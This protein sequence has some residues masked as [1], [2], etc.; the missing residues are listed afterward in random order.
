VNPRAQPLVIGVAECVD[1]PAWKIR[2]LP[3][4]VDTGARSCALHV[5][6][7]REL[8]GGHVRFD[9]P[10]SPG[11][12][13][14]CMTIDA[15]VIRRGRV[16]STSGEAKP[17]LF[18][19]ARIR[20]GPLERQVELGLVDRRQMQFPMLIGRSAIARACLVD[21][22]RTYLITG[23]PKSKKQREL[24][25][26]IAAREKRV[27]RRK[28]DASRVLASHTRDGGRKRSQ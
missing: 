3:A 10:L 16:R 23:R 26:S 2:G 6:N 19:S 4:K 13:D 11:S 24:Q 25:R 12:P 27:A 15:R 22:S 21:V 28:P 18:V 14:R 9:V 8:P 7:L 5:E 20:L 1:I 17:R